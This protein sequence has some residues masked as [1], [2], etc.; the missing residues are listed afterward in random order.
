MT[1]VSFDV[2]VRQ[3]RE[4]VEQLVKEGEDLISG[5]TVV[6]NKCNNNLHHHHCH[7]NHH[8]H[9]RHDD[10]DHHHPC[11][12][13]EDGDVRVKVERAREQL[14]AIQVHF[15]FNLAAERERLRIKVND[16]ECTFVVVVEDSTRT[17]CC[18]YPIIFREHCKD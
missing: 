11:Q 8:N 4:K 5:E 10:D 13:D 16:V 14:A 17:T 1:K 15:Y 6:V 12:G 2:K 18:F 9:H 7:Y 3:Q